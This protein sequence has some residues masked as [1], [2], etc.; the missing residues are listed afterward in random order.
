MCQVGLVWEVYHE[1]S[2]D[3]ANYDFGSEW[4]KPENTPVLS[5]PA[6]YWI[7][8]ISCRDPD[9]YGWDHES[10]T[11]LCSSM[12]IL[13][14]LNI[15][16][17]FL[18]VSSRNKVKPFSSSTFVLITCCVIYMKTVKRYFFSSIHKPPWHIDKT[19]PSSISRGVIMFNRFGVYR[20]SL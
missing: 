16:D 5:K 18:C 2:F 14:Y 13:S 9:W 7:L 11:N 12:C 1:G 19:R 3:W 8:P 4:N 10:L 15:F 6:T 20:G 17:D